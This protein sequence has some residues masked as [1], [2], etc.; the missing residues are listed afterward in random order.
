[1]NGSFSFA[2]ISDVFGPTV[3]SENIPGTPMEAIDALLVTEHD[4][5]HSTNS[6]IAQDLNDANVTQENQNPIVRMTRRFSDQIDCKG[7]SKDSATMNSNN[8][9]NSERNYKRGSVVSTDE[10]LSKHRNSRQL[11]QEVNNEQFKIDSAI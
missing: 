5:N 2:N 3:K 11:D 7:G 4:E 6:S 10:S 9:T 8:G 1:M